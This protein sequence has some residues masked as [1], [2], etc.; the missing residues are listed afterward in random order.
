MSE[1]DEVIAFTGGVHIAHPIIDLITFKNNYAE[2]PPFNLLVET[3][4]SVL[5]QAQALSASRRVPNNAAVTGFFVDL[6][7]IVMGIFSIR[8]YIS[9]VTRKASWLKAQELA[10]AGEGPDPHRAPEVDMSENRLKFSRQGSV[11]Y[12]FEGVEKLARKQS[13]QPYWNQAMRLSK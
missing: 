5:G 8:Y 7:V 11:M 9:R 1:Q 12:T 13:L 4:N 2:H 10:D 3:E 6:T